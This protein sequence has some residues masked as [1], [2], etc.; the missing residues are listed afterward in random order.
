MDCFNLRILSCLRPTTICLLWTILLNLY[1]KFRT[2]TCVF[3][4]SW[5]NVSKVTSEVLKIMEQETVSLTYTSRSDIVFSNAA[6]EVGVID[7][8]C[9]IYLWLWYLQTKELTHSQVAFYNINKCKITF[10]WLR[11]CFGTDTWLFCEIVGLALLDTD[12]CLEAEA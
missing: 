11:V 10:C 6:T 5:Q 12:V 3:N 7:Y 9:Y 4:V 8:F 2:S 1:G